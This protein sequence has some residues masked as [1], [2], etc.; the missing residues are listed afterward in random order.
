M[1]RPL[2]L[3][4]AVPAVLALVLPLACAHSFMTQPPAYNKVFQTRSCKG[5]E[6]TNA[7][8]NVLRDESDMANTASR[9]AAEWRR[10]EEV[11]IRWAKNNHRAGMVRVS[12]VPADSMMSRDWHARLSLF[13]GCWES[14]EYRCSG[15]LCGSDSDHEG[16]QRKVLVPDVF[17]DGLY[18][19]AVVWYGGLHFSRERG[20]FPDYFSCAFVRVKGGNPL[21]GSYQPVWA[22]GDTGPHDAVKMTGDP[23]KGGMCQ[24]AADRVGECP[25]TGCTGPSFW[26]VSK[27]FQGGR[28]PDKIT[29]RIVADAFA[30]RPVMGP[31]EDA[32]PQVDTKPDSSTPAPETPAPETPVKPDEPPVDTP[33]AP[34]SAADLPVAGGG[35]CLGDV[36]CPRSC[37]RCGGSGCH[38]RPGGGENCCFSRIKEAGKMCSSNP[39]PC[40]RD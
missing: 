20:Q 26:A 19:A 13:H 6:C 24:T 3:L 1:P 4:L 23:A 38:R 18:V 39:P 2:A 21:A 8:P 32:P 40:V 16:F 37:G 27:A 28:K 11:M 31:T 22:P 35:L 9:P 29:P 15:A 25:K 5:S 14:G 33:D 34:V 17:P 30:Q 12:L 10:G 7:C 36:C